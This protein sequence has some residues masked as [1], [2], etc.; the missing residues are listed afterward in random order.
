MPRL[1]PAALIALA[2]SLALA[3]CD[4]PE[5]EPVAAPQPTR[6]SAPPPPPEP[7]RVATLLQTMDVDPRVSFPDAHAPTD[8]QLARSVISLA[9]AI[10]RGDAD[11]L[12][13]LLDEGDR[14]VLDTLERNGGWEAST[15]PLEQVRVAAVTEEQV[16]LA[17]QE[18]GLAYPLVWAVVTDGSQ[19]T[20]RGQISPEENARFASAFDSNPSGGPT[21]EIDSPSMSSPP[22][23]DEPE[24]R[25]EPERGDGPFGLTV[26][27]PRIIARMQ[28]DPEFAARFQ[29]ATQRDSR[30]IL[31]SDPLTQWIAFEIDVQLAKALSDSM[32]LPFDADA[33][34]DETAA[35]LDMDADAIRQDLE[36]G[37]RQAAAG[38]LPSPA[39]IQSILR[40]YDDDPPG[41]GQHPQLIIGAIAEILGTDIE[42]IRGIY[43]PGE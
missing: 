22:A 39:S 33:A 15:T 21:P 10:A 18:P 3:G 28:R 26:P 27:S 42:T 34:I 2:L 17:L 23:T 14:V 29:E 19:I 9:D 25:V 4:E 32:G 38:E 35:T 6:R 41:L 1:K 24:A 11:D 13:P 12:R 5:Q 30:E 7:V 36:E 8:E 16:T 43:D 20:F 31:G 40:S 37:E